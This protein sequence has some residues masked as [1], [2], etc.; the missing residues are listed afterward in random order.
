MSGR[1]RK[2][3]HYT[4]AISWGVTVVPTVLWWSQSILWVAF[5]SI[6]AIVVGHWGAAEGAAAKQ[7]TE[8][9]S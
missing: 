2:W 5:M 8:E 1:I 7:T 6:Y 9:K 4:L 3:C